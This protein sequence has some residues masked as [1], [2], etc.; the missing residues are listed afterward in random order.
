M[1]EAN[2][3]SGVSDM[4]AK[5]LREKRSARE[6]QE[7]RHADW[8]DNY[9]L[10]RNKVFTNRL[11]Q[12]QAVNVPLMK[13]TVKTL[14]SKIDD[15][16]EVEWKEKSG[17]MEK[18]VYLQEI[19]NTEYSEQ[20]FEGIDMLDKKNVLMYGR[21]F[22]KLNWKD[23]SVEIAALDVYDVVIDPLV[24]PLDV[25]SARFVIHQNLFKSLRE[26]LAD[27]RYDG[28]GR[29][30]LKVHLTTP[31][32]M[33]QSGKNK[34]EWEK[35][36]ERLKAMGVTSAEF[37]HF[38]AGDVIVNL[39]EHYTSE[40]DA[41]E[42]RFVR[43]VVVYADD[44]FE[45]MDEKLEDLIGVDFWPFVTW[46]EDVET[47]DFWSD[48]PAD[49]VRTPNKVVNVWF[50]QQVENRTLRNF[51]MHWYDATVQGYT[52]QT[53]EPGPGRMLPAPGNPSA[54]I[55]PVQV[56]GLDE[57]FNAIDFLTKMVER[58]T[59]ATAIDKGTPEQQDM[60]LGEV[61]I[62]VGNAMERTLGMAKFYRRAWK[63]LAMKWYRMMDANDSKKRNLVKISSKGRVWPKDVFPSDW[64]SKAGFFSL[65]R[66]SSE[67]DFEK[68]KGIQRFDFLMQKFP[69]NAALK[70][71]AQKRMLGLLDLSPEEVREVADDEKKRLD[72]QERQAEAQELVM[73]QAPQDTG[74]PLADA[75]SKVA[76]ASNQEALRAKLAEL[77]GLAGGGQIQQSLSEL[78]NAA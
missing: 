7:R 32:G 31:E 19:W 28:P 54:T 30:K 12:R 52:P 25:E 24:N 39:T 77:G 78:A 59:A 35:K 27:D 48:G 13:E 4:M 71:I 26:V 37:P 46:G 68:T 65:V 15:P 10:Y 50:S 8:D 1:P 57:T 38:A 64:K 62:L 47:S 63:E 70:R 20:D 21:A 44:A 33:I 58:G 2:I 72:E 60:T 11:T 40:W 23:G 43:K 16:P 9:Q 55:L 69:E 73:A 76:S 53:Y 22:R 51:Q 36:M 61:K 14:L 5:L 49:L 6:Y 66:S 74:N 45:L 56:D 42:K 29:D 34:E 18:E 67:Q 3:A 17:N 41:K 75:A